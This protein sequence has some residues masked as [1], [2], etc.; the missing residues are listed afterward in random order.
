MEASKTYWGVFPNIWG[1]P[2]VWGHME[3]PPYDKARFL[4]A[5]NVQGVS[6]CIGFYI[7]GTTKHMDTSKHMGASKHVGPSKHMRSIQI[8]EGIQTYRGC[9]QTNGGIQTYRGYFPNIWGASKHTGGH[10]DIQGVSKHGEHPN[11]WG[12][13]CMPFYPMKQVSPLVCI[14]VLNYKDQVHMKFDSYLTIIL[15]VGLL[16]FHEFP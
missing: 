4:C 6:K 5:V 2:N 16:L 1:H 7:K 15:L 14:Q 10:P 8:Y 13:S 12:H 3:T 11:I 9:F